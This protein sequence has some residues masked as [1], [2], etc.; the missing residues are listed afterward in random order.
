MK[1]LKS[2]LLKNES[3]ATAVYVA[4]VLG[5]LLMFTALAIDVNHLYGVR[6]EL[7]N[8]ADGGALAGAITLFNSDGTLNRQ[9]A[10]DEA[11]RIAAANKTGNQDVSE[12]DVETGHWSF[13]NKQ[14]TA[15]AATTQADWHERPFSELDLDTDFINA[16]WVKTDR[17][18]TPS[19][20]ARILGFNDFSVSTD[21]VA[22]IGFAGTLSPGELDQPIAICKESIIDPDG[23]YSCNM[24]RMLNSGG[25]TATSN[26]GGWTNFTQPCETASATD[27]RDLVCASGNTEG[28]QFGQGIGATGGVQDNVLAD[29]Y[30]CWETNTYDETHTRNKIINWNLTLPVVECPGNNVSNCAN[31]VG[32][33][34]VNVVWIVHQ[35]DPHYDEVPRE[36]TVDGGPTWTCTDPD[37]FTCW[38]SFI[39]NFNLANVDGPPM[40]DEEYEEMY[41]KK[42]IFFLPDCTVHEPRG[43]SG[44]ENFGILARIPKLVE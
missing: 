4:I 41:Q 29:L 18:D 40:T 44:G 30:D 23:T 14:F 13:T 31:L 7:H 17:S 25:N 20:F 24:G 8:A 43:R 27:M 11:N 33:V 28:V 37:G 3:G 35:N 10:L 16:V 9:G 42:N 2:I 38:K 32:A 5:V 1:P 22:Y 12:I 36:M 39:D 6:N 19:F 26:T 34:S 21:A 15:N